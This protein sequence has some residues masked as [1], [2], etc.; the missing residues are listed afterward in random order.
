VQLNEFVTVTLYVPAAEATM[1][2]ALAPVLHEYVVPF[3]ARRM[4]L[5]PVHI[6]ALPLVGAGVQDW[7]KRGVAEV[8]AT[9]SESVFIFISGDLYHNYTERFLK[10]EIPIVM[11]RLRRRHVTA[12]L[13]LVLYVPNF[14]LPY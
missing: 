8:I 5:P 13:H 14:H 10:N 11:I 6:V 1:L 9:R 4:A 3:V 7:E 12:L 2:S